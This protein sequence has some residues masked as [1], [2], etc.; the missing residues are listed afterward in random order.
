MD[1]REAEE[2]V[3]MGSE[4]TVHRSL[5]YMHAL[6]EAVA[7]VNFAQFTLFGF[8]G[9]MEQFLYKEATE[10]VEEAMDKMTVSF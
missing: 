10:Q 9:N 8:S 7:D 5:E 3:A 1:T 2:G 6:D 4:C